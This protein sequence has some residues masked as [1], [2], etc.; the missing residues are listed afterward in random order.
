MAEQMR[1]VI[2]ER[3]RPLMA[4]GPEHVI[5]HLPAGPDV[6]DGW[7]MPIRCGGGIA[8][9]GGTEKVPRSLICPDCLRNPASPKSEES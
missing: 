9:H 5:Y 3:N 7:W 1:V 2:A 6:D 4:S 8:L